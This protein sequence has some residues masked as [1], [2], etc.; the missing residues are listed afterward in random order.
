MA[1][2]STE[3]LLYFPI[4]TNFVE[5]RKIRR[6][7]RAQ[8]AKALAVWVVLMAKIYGEKGYYIDFDDDLCFDIGEL[9]NISDNL[10]SEIIYTAL[11]VN[12][13]DSEMFT[14][15]SIITSKGIQKQYIEIKKAKKNKINIKKEYALILEEITEN[16]ETIPKKRKEFSKNGINSQ[17][18]ELIGE[19][20]ELMQQRKEKK[21]KEN[22]RKENNSSSGSNNINITHEQKDEQTTATATTTEKDIRHVISEWE[23]SGYPMINGTNI[24]DL[25]HLTEF[26]G[27]EFVIYAIHEGNDHNKANMG[28]VKGV[29]HGLRRDNITTVEQLKSRKDKHLTQTYGRKNNKAIKRVELT[30]E[31]RKAL[32]DVDKPMSQEDIDKIFSGG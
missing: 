25:Q 32:N 24:Q 17:K 8:G 7:I 18:M 2:I 26:Y 16:S 4:D 10:V 1:R 9:V 19:N 15:Y 20:S 3:S 5:N 22:K 11:K 29:L 27:A 30:Q 6:L 23:N 31:E 12:L 28:Y 13:F 21:S 14:K